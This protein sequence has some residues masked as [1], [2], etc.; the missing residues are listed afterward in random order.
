MRLEPGFERRIKL[1]EFDRHMLGDRLQVIDPECGILHLRKLLPDTASEQ[2][3]GSPA[4]EL[5][6]GGVQIGK[7]PV[8]VDGKE[9]IR[10]AGQDVLRLL[11]GLAELVFDALSVADVVGHADHAIDASVLIADR[12]GL[13]VYP[14]N[15]AVR[16]DDAILLVIS[17]LRLLFLQS[18]AYPLAVVVVD[19]LQP[20]PRRRLQALAT[21]LPDLLV[22][23]ADVEHL[24]LFRIGHPEHLAYVFRDLPEAFV[25]AAQFSHHPVAL[26]NIARDDYDDVSVAG[27]DRAPHQFDREQ[28]AILQTVI[29][30]QRRSVI[31]A[32]DDAIV[33]LRQLV[34]RE[35]RDVLWPHLQELRPAVPEQ[36]AGSVV[37]IDEAHAGPV[38]EQDQVR[39]EVHGGAELAQRFFRTDAFAD[40]PHHGLDCRSAFK[41]KGS[42]FDL[43][44]HGQAVH[45]HQ[46]LHHARKIA[47]LLVQDTHALARDFP[48][49]R[50]D[51]IEQRLPEQLLGRRRA[52]QPHECAIHEHQLAVL[53]YVD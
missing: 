35:R 50:M 21:A 34:A 5:L 1:L 3:G 30:F 19:G 27:R 10:D 2:L 36:P 49:V 45:S 53:M 29:H 23:R 28:R 42:G 9:R 11:R 47:F 44:V 39:R 38:D 24:V 4:E 32:S 20:G 43:D 13:V 17:S 51:E 41:R 46:L 8:L 26:R 31:V 40:V 16:P 18:R 6:C 52:E 48:L 25:A 33:G 37:D 22:G 12:E 7:A 14:A 15:S